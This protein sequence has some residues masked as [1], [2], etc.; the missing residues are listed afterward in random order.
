VVTAHFLLVDGLI[1][2]QGPV[3]HVIAKGVTA[4]RPPRSLFGA[5]G[6]ERDQL[7]L[8]FSSRDFH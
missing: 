8:P 2:R 6:D 7:D 1:E 3:V 4:V 5:L